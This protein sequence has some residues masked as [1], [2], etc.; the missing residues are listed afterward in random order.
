MET[1]ASRAWSDLPIAPGEVLLEELQARNMTQKE[2]ASKLGRP[3]QVINEIV[4]AKKAI[5]P[6]TA[7]GLEDVLGIEAQ[8]WVNLESDYQMA[9]A[10][11]RD[12]EKLAANVENLRAFPIQEM[13]KLGW[14]DAGRDRISKLKALQEFFG[15]A[16]TEPQAI[17]SAVGFRIT[18]AAQRKV[19]LGALAV[20]LRKGE[21]EAQD[22]PVS[23]YSEEVFRKVLDNIRQLI[24]Q[25]PN[26]FIPA[27]SDLC[28]QA[29]VAF[30]LVQ[31]LKKSGANGV[32]RRLPNGTPMIQVS[33]RFKWADIFWF[34]FFHEA[35]HVLQSLGQRQIVIDGLE[36]D[37]ELKELEAEADMFAR[38]L[39]IPT[40]S[41]A[42]FC[43]EAQFT[44][45]SI[46]SFSQ[47]IDIAPFVVVGRLQKEGLVSYQ[48]FGHL[49][50]RYSW[51]ELSPS[52]RPDVQ[53]VK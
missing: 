50:K 41:W 27:M 31:E 51:K 29:G 18:E 24:S 47:S 4:K 42:R 36:P 7:I 49:K 23:E 13:L 32:M 16:I 5:T 17:Q 25:P 53:A 35:G 15:M 43:E 26:E 14:M 37:P 6:D 34:T 11:K 8:F 3:P 40:A 38:D 48:E 28:A 1:R 44:D 21:L 30:C 45:E 19:S 2:L 39:L 10:R 20:W 22:I 52:D 46:L 9:L 12:Q 33:L